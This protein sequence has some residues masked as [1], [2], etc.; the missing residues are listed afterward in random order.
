MASFEVTCINYGVHYETIFLRTQAL[1]VYCQESTCF[2]YDPLVLLNFSTEEKVSCGTLNSLPSPLS[3]L[4][5]S[6][7]ALDAN[8]KRFFKGV[9]MLR[10]C[11]EKY[12]YI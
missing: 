11:T 7:V 3:L 8:I 1:V 2:K 9:Q 10:P 12:D 6:N 5:S 4:L